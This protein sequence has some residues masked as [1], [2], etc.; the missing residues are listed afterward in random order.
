MNGR[1]TRQSRSVK[2]LRDSVARKIAAGE[3]IDRPNSVVRELL[4]NS[5]DAG[6]TEISLYLENGG[7]SRIRVVDNGCGMS[8][9]DLRLCYLPHATSKI[10]TEDDLLSINSLGFRGE[11]LSSI[12]TCTR[13]EVVSRREEDD[14]AHRLIV[15]GG[16]EIALEDWRGSRGTIIDASELFYSIPARKKFLKRSSAETTMCQ[17]TFLEK[18]LPFPEISFKLYTDNNLK[19][20]LPASTRKERI[21]AAWK[22]T[23]NP[24]LL[25][26]LESEDE[27]FK[28]SIIAGRPEQNRKDRRYIQIFANNRRIDEYAFIQ[29]VQYGFD[30]A[31]P[32]GV[33]PVCFVFIE[34]EPHLV[35]FNIHPAKREARF[36]NQPAIHH[37]IV[38]MIKDFLAEYTFRFRTEE[39]EAQQHTFPS[40]E[41][42]HPS[43]APPAAKKTSWNEWRGA[44]ASGSNFYGKANTSFQG[45]PATHYSDSYEP[46]QSVRETMN[47]I[48]PLVDKVPEQSDDFEGLRYMGQIM[49][50]FLLA[51][52][53]NRLFIVDQHAAHERI[54]FEV[55]KKKASAVQEL[56]IP[57]EFETDEAEEI[58]LEKNKDKYRDLGISVNRLQQ[59]LWQMTSIPKSALDMEGDLVEFLK[60]QQGS[61][62]ELEKELYATMSCRAAVKDG[63]PVDAL[64]ALELIKGA[65]RL[66]S[67]RCPH[68]RPIWF[69]LSKDELFELV[70]RVI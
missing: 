23:F 26:E 30:D 70:G 3:V 42:E 68:G 38:Q 18:A 7:I 63:D 51:E 53:D 34:V 36:R 55:F 58:N 25:H 65:F 67:A 32:G 59:G 21:L 1:D 24:S 64:S 62:G 5:I 39:K 48:T 66:E 29:A 14:T 37:K 10:E 69:E 4:D 61:I 16:R 44:A 20:F 2:M 27:G 31:L 52:Y 47:R 11:A 9:E 35:D 6:S 46:V 40:R 57:V 17:K 22:G 28:I 8:E 45:M 12:S 50:L 49:D 54:L 43:F 41:M 33:F 19:L 13:M 56:L 15:H 60:T